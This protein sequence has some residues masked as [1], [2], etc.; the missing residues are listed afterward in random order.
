MEIILSKK[1]KAFMKELPEGSF[2]IVTPNKDGT[3]SQIGLT[4][5]QSEMLTV[6]LASISSEEYPLRKLPK[7]YNL[8]KVK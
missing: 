5:S 4:Q 7:E 3:V 1:N 6:F 8:E 2:G